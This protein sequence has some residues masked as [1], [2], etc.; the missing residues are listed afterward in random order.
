VY[1]S[2]GA[3]FEYVKQEESKN[4]GNEEWGTVPTL[5]AS[6]LPQAR[7]SFSNAYYC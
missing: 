4:F 6:D 7:L 5:S 3:D 1:N 2:S